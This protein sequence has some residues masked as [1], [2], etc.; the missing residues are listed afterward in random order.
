MKTRGLSVCV[1]AAFLM[2][3]LLSCDR[4]KSPGPGPE[5]KAKS[6]AEK[7]AEAPELGKPPVTP[8]TPDKIAIGKKAP[9]FVLEDQNGKNLGLSGYSGKIVVL[10]WLNYDCPF[11]IR[12]HAAGTMKALAEKYTAKG[13]VWLAVN[14]TNY[15]THDGDRKFAAEHKIPFSILSDPPGKVGRLYGAKTTPH[16]FIIGKDGNLAYMG[17]IDDDPRDM[18]EKPFNYVDAALQEL[19]DGKPVSKPE[20]KPYGC[21]V[22]YKK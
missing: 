1:V 14:S 22:K 18:K 5:S 19:I 16:M 4:G 15:A 21:S 13:V 3:V 9:D 17:A 8:E 2:V 20:T 11:S 12:H 7:P 10:E 6:T